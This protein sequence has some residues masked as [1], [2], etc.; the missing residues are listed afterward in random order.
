MAHCH[1]RFPPATASSG[2]HAGGMTQ[3][4]ASTGAATFEQLGDMGYRCYSFTVG[5]G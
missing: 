1:D 3:M 2:Q 5:R 4:T